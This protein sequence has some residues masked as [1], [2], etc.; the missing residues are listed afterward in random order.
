MARNRKPGPG[1]PKG[2]ISVPPGQRK[3]TCSVQ[4]DAG[5]R[6]A[7]VAFQEAECLDSMSEAVRALVA[8][9]LQAARDEAI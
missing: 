2:S 8:K 6:A 5:E 3:R 7:I 9:G 1:R 4:F